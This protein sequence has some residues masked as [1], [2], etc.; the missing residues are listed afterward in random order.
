MFALPDDDQCL[1]LGGIFGE[2][3]VL[4]IKNCV[5]FDIYWRSQQGTGI[6]SSSE[7]LFESYDFAIRISEALG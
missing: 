3:F 4:A 5:V 1:S 2:Q 6:V 7:N